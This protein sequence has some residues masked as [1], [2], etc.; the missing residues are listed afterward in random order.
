MFS[1]CRQLVFTMGKP[2]LTELLYKKNFPL[3]G[4]IRWAKSSSQLED[5]PGAQPLM[6]TP[7]TTCKY[8]PLKG[9]VILQS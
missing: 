8:C 5:L 6:I 9:N 2:F 7:D 4:H 3:D 1:A